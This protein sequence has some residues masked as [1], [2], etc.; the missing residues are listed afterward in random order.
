M[1]NTWYL[2]QLSIV[3]T[4]ALVSCQADR[5]TPPNSV[6]IQNEFYTFSVP[7]GYEVRYKDTRLYLRKESH[8]TIILAPV[9]LLPGDTPDKVLSEVEPLHLRNTP[10]RKVVRHWRGKFPIA[11]SEHPALYV[12]QLQRRDGRQLEVINSYVL[13]EGWLLGVTIIGENIHE[14]RRAEIEALLRHIEFRK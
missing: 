3:F 8:Y 11:G 7:D 14:A 2:A 12:V 6:R 4:V 13:R 10:E 5:A 1:R 9:E